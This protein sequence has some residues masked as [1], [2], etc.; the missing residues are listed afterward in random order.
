ME[1]TPDHLLKN[2]VGRF[3]S[4]LLNPANAKSYSDSIR[5]SP[6]FVRAV[7][8]KSIETLSIGEK[9][10]QDSILAS[11]PHG[12]GGERYADPLNRSWINFAQANCQKEI[13]KKDPIALMDCMA[14]ALMKVDQQESN[15]GRPLFPL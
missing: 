2:Y 13:W 7:E 10:V 3:K 15:F 12:V 14:N 8:K 4:Y 1:I 9:T 5:R 6:S 11:A